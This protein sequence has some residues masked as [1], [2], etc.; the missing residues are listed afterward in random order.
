AMLHRERLDRGRKRLHPLPMPLNELPD[1]AMVQAGDESY[2]IVQ[3]RALQWS[4]AGYRAVSDAI[5]DAMLLTPPS[6]LRALSRGY[7]PVLHPSASC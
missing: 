2:L 4:M 7:R 5:E 6:T 3:G 1:G